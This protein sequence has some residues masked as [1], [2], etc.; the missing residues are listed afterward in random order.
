VLNFFPAFLIRR[1]EG[2]EWEVEASSWIEI[3]LIVE[4]Y[5]TPTTI[6]KNEAAASL[7]SRRGC[8][9]LNDEKRNWG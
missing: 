5:L 9:V 3:S 8:G 7:S 1:N 4:F 6:N 2:L